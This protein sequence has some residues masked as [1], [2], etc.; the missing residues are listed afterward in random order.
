MKIIV[1]GG[2]GAIGS[3]IVNQLK[4]SSTNE[5]YTVGHKNGKL[6]TYNFETPSFDKLVKIGP[7]DAV[8]WAGGKNAN[9][10]I[11]NVENESFTQIMEA[12]LNFIIRS[13]T[14]LVNENML[15]NNSSLVVISSIWQHLSRNNKLSYSVSKSALSGLI[16]STA[17]DL[18]KS[19]IRVNSVSPGVVLNEMTKKNLSSEQISKI[20]GETP[21]QRL[22]TEEEIANTVLW[23]ISDASSG[24]TGQDLIV[25]G[26]WSV[27]RHV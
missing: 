25:D 15:A 7:F 2:N 6:L 10:S 12:N 21:L 17:I 14:F 3:E 9:D 24:L 18:G 22:V 26:G 20:A 16:K 8:I 1:F 5:V 27:S 4:K 13:M 19:N 23:L 11:I